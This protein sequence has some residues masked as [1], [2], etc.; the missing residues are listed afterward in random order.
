[1]WKTGIHE[2][3]KQTRLVKKTMLKQVL[4]KANSKLAEGLK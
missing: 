4:R 2:I 3:G 1:M